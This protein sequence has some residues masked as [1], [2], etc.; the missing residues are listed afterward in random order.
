MKNVFIAVF[1][2]IIFSGCA[3][4]KSYDYADYSSSLKNGLSFYSQYE[5]IYKIKTKKGEKI[6]V[7]PFLADSNNYLP[8][9]ILKLHFGLKIINPNKEHFK[10]WVDSKFTEIGTDKVFQKLNFVH[11]AQ[12]LPEEFV[13]I[14]LPLTNIHSKVEFFVIITSDSGDILYSSLARYKIKGVNLVV[15]KSNIINYKKGEKL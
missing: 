12:I 10:I 5:I 11:V 9:K 2:C 13:S 7:S 1:L 6:I 14:N 4:T 15:K 8:E 3:T